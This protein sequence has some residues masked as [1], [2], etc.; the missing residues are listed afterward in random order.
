[1]KRNGG[2]KIITRRDGKYRGN[3]CP[4]IVLLL[5]LFIYLRT[6]VFVRHTCAAS[7]LK[8]RVS[9]ARIRNVLIRHKLPGKP[10]IMFERPLIWYLTTVL[11]RGPIVVNRFVQIIVV[12]NKKYDCT[13][14]FRDAR[15]QSEREF[16][17][18]QY[19]KHANRVKRKTLSCC[20]MNG[21]ELRLCQKQNGNL[22]FVK[23]RVRRLGVMM[24]ECGYLIFF[25]F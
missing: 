16:G 2:M 22:N 11:E 12:Y 3:N 10:I 4:D 15:F 24:P 25:F 18:S 9:L 17:E 20:W 23:K 21:K 13:H 1:M 14:R 7:C 5:L 19:S 6:A 8:Y